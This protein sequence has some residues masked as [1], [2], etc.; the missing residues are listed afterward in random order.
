[1][2]H[3]LRVDDDLD[4]VGWRVEQ[5]VRLDHLQAL[6]HHGRGVDGD[7]APHHP[8]RVRAG[9]VRCDR[10]ELF[11]RQRA[12]R[13]TGSGQDDAAHARR[14]EIA[15]IAGGQRLEHGIVLTV[16]RQQ[17][18][19]VRAHRIHEHRTRHHQRF[20]VGEQHPFAS[21]GSGE[22]GSE[23]GG[24]DDGR[25][26]AV[27][28]R[29]HRDAVETGRTGQ[30]LALDTGG[31]Q[32][33]VEFRGRNRIEHGG[34]PRPMFQALLEQ[35]VD[36]AVRREPDDAEPVGMPRHHVERVAPDGTGGPQDTQA[37]HRRTLTASTTARSPVPRTAAR[38]PVHR[39]DR[40]SRRDRAA[41]CHCP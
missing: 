38:Q 21:A 17:G 11:A 9:L 3:A 31:A 35:P 4:A 26:H 8:V 28:L 18:R 36:L 15:G 6:V 2:H 5:P 23:S 32:A 25:H 41:P 22:R 20:L 1:M 40:V 7:L 34:E 29:R 16:D 19:P 30:H 10:R 27:G 14:I 12:E 13:P 24:A 33:G 39:Y 37:A